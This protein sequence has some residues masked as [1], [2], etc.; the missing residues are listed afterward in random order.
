MQFDC[1][2]VQNT[3][4]LFSYIQEI[5]G[6]NNLFNRFFVYKINVSQKETYLTATKACFSQLFFQSVPYFPF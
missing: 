3:F 2:F 1:I 5:A 4:Q 6:E